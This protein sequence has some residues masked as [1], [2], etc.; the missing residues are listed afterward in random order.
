MSPSTPAAGAGTSMVTLSV[1]S[2]T[3]GS[4][5]ET[6][7]PGFLNHLPVV[8]LVTKT[9]RVGTRISTMG[10]LLRHGRALS[11]PSTSLVRRRRQD[12]DARRKAVPGMTTQMLS[13]RFL[14]ELLELREVNRHLPDRGGRCRGPSCVARAAA[15]GADLV[16]HPF[17]E[18]VDEHP[19]AHIARLLLAPDNLGLLEARQ[20][21]HQ[22][23]R[24][25]RIKLLDTQQINVIETAFLA[26]VVKVVIDLAGAEDDAAHLVVGD[27]LNLLVRQRLGVVPEQ[28]VERGR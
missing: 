16:E 3:S 18:D 22:R 19:R 26:F 7:S 25:E 21:R 5:A 2:S 1:S 13:Q 14:K 15:L 20:L 8:A 4:S 9:K 27:E 17:E 23:L 6:V 10:Q 12:V 24:G 11:R 28:A